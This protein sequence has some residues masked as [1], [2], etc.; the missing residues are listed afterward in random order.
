MAKI[1]VYTIAL[2]EEKHVKRW[3]ESAKDADFL[4]IADTGSTDSTAF[5]S[6]SL[7][8]ATYKIEVKPW[9]FDVARNAALALIPGD[10]DL[11]ISM[12]MDEV[13]MPG[14]R[15]AIE[16]DFAKGINFPSIKLVLGRDESGNPINFFDAPRA[17][18]RQGFYWKYPIHEVITPQVG[19]EFNRGIAKAEMEHIPDRS[20]SRN[21]YI[22]LLE[23]ARLE[24]PT[25]WRM[26]HYLIREYHYYGKH[27]ELLRLSEES[28]E[29]KD[30]WSIERSSVCIWASNAAWQ[31]GLKQY[32]IQWARRATK[33]A[34][35]FYEAWHWRAHIA[36]LLG[37]WNET[38]DSASKI[39]SL[40]R[41]RHHLVKPEVW[42]WWGYDLVALSSHRLGNHKEAVKYGE[43][44]LQGSPNDSRLRVNLDFYKSSLA[45]E[46]GLTE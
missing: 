19:V 24:F 15:T 30:G 46:Q 10:V 18:P 2:N 31:L 4:L 27:L 6:K 40:E 28:L 26:A 14:W 3:Y 9:R 41:H 21:S 7:G 11:C 39:L 17:H 1:A 29:S 23:T 16:E 33:E 44:A 45:A 12:D 42:N 20:K 13:L 8:I 34:P 36:H 38:Y 35:D 37:D 32:S 5:I 43:L 22:E 25:D